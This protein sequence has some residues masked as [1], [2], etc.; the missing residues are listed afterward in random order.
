MNKNACFFTSIL[1]LSLFFSCTTKKTSSTLTR[2]KELQIQKKD[3]VAPWTNLNLNNSEDKFHFAIV[4]DRTGG[5]REGVFMDAVNKLNLLQPE[6]V[7][8]VGDLI[9]GYTEDIDELNRQWDEF[10]GFVTNLDMPFFYL[11]GNHD[12][13]N[14]VME[15]L[16]KERLGATYYH[17]VYHNVLFL[18][19]NTEDQKRGAGKGTI[20]TEQFEYAKRV[21]SENQNVDWTLIFMHQPLWNQEDTKR[22]G[23]IDQLL[24]ERKHTVYTGHEHRYVKYR[25]NNANY[26]ILGTTG[27]ASSLRGAKMGEFDHV[28]WITMTNEGPIMANLLLEGIKDDAVFTEKMREHIEKLG[29]NNPIQITPFYM[30][31][32]DFTEGEVQIKITNDENYPM[33]VEFVEKASMDI[34]GLIEKTNLTVQ[35]NSVEILK[36]K[37]R[38]RK[39]SFQDPMQLNAIVSYQPED[40]K[41]TIEFPY[42]FNIK[43][44]PKYYLA[45]VTQEIKVDGNPEEWKDYQYSY[46]ENEGEMRVEFSVKYDSS[47]IYFAAR[48]YD[49]DIQ[50][51]GTG[52]AWAQD[53]I[54]FGV[55]ALPMARSAM[56]VGRHWY[57]DEFY[58]LVTPKTKEAESVIYRDFPE[59]ADMVCVATK[60]GYFAEAKLPIS[61]IEKR[62]GKNWKSIRIQVVVDDKDGS[63]INRFWWQPNWMNKQNNVVGSGMFFRK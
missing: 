52:A 23:E 60:D 30:E 12:M 3:K 32:D 11:P 35:P 61:Y 28:A 27:G 48:V 44:L 26:Y 62:Q 53:N 2:S 36:M 54:G 1:I 55:S 8:S 13:T 42:I 25:R 17:F 14:Q 57:K 51:Y 6:F 38:K 34:I 43:P 47:Y 46:T 24:K 45:K 50:S 58:Q 9:E 40:M 5:H 19:L 31:G 20:S 39:F 59:G 4:T 22:W 63:K 21:L 15:D 56:S 7:M 18:A 10:D 41:T 29:T 37:I 16:W 33:Q 49:T